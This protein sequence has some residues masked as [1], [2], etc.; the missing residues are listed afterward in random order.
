MRQILIIII[1]ALSIAT[2]IKAQ[3]ITLG[4]IEGQ[5]W[6]IDA[7]GNPFFATAVTHISSVEGVTNEQMRDAILSLGFNAYGYGTPQSMTDDGIPYIASWNYL[8]VMSSYYGEKIEYKDIF[9][10]AIQQQI[11]K[12]ISDLCKVNRDNKNL[13]GYMWT[14]LPVWTLDEKPGINWLVFMR[15]LNSK[16]PGKRAYVDYLKQRYQGDFVKFKSIYNSDASSWEELLTS[17]FDNIP[18]NKEQIVNDDNDFLPIIAQQYYK[19]LYESNKRYD[20]NHII[21]GDRFTPNWIHQGVFQAMLPYVDAIAIQ[22]LYA[23]PFERAKVKYDK[24]HK[25]SSGKPLMICDYAVRFYEQGLDI[26]GATMEEE[27]AGEQY[28]NYIKAAFNSPYIIGTS[29]CQPVSIPT[30]NNKGVKQGL[31]SDTTLQPREI[32]HKYIRK[33]NNYIKDNTPTGQH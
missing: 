16:A 25:M 26:S 33:T 2:P 30:L 14:D 3:Y 20:P 24:I 13:I 28:Y 12:M 1:L 22:P 29:W 27:Q 7:E 5:Q 18:N 9:D 8:I 4:E 10:P 23:E 21:F 17:S 19:T 11:D 31:Y 15:N 6:L 32:L